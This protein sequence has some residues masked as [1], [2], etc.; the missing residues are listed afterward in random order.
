[1][2][3]KDIPAR[4]TVYA[5]IRMRSRLE[6][7][8]ARHLDG[9]GVKWAYEPECFAGPDGQYLPDFQINP[10]DP[11][12]VEVK[13]ADLYLNDLEGGDEKILAVLRRMEVVWLSK[14]HAV[15]NLV[16]WRYGADCAALSYMGGI[17]D[18]WMIDGLPGVPLQLTGPAY[19]RNALW[20]GLW[21][22]T[23]SSVIRRS[24]SS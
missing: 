18:A 8:C 4:P 20:G 3:P 16:L 11:I 22:M 21:S 9:M 5:G 13:P 14:P 19:G 15:L 17:S 6:A 1:M 12:Y 7:D 10:P 23:G 24:H 2:G